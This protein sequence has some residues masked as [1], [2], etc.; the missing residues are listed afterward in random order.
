VTITRDGVWVGQPPDFGPCADPHNFESSS[1]TRQ[2]APLIRS[3]QLGAHYRPSADASARPLP[4][5][6]PPFGQSVPNDRSRS[7]LVVSHH[8]DGLL[9]AGFASTELATGRGSPRFFGPRKGP[10]SRPIARFAPAQRYTLEELPRQS[11]PNLPNVGVPTAS[12]ARPDPPVAR[13]PSSRIRWRLP[14]EVPLELPS[15]PG[16]RPGGPVEHVAKRG[17]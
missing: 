17:L 13:S 12:S 15:G 14:E 7:A 6:E 1:A 8:L 2:A 10:A 5:G 9:R 16:L 11:G 4:G 3:V